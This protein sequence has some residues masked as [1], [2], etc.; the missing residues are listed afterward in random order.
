M[1]YYDNH[2]CYVMLQR[3]GKCSYLIMLLKYLFN[4]AIVQGTF[5]YFY[6]C[7]SQ[8]KIIKDIKIIFS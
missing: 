2:V 8:K 5:W 4:D 6:F 3:K 1:I 7:S